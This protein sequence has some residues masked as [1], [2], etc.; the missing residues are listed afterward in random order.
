MK[1]IL[2]LVLATMFFVFSCG[3]SDKIT[4]KTVSEWDKSYSENEGGYEEEDDD[5][6]FCE[7]TGEEVVYCIRGDY[8]DEVVDV[9]SIKVGEKEFKC[10]SGN[11]RDC[12]VKMAIYCGEFDGEYED[13]LYC[14]EGGECSS[15]GDSVK[16]CMSTTGDEK[17]YYQVGEKKFECTV[18]TLEDCL[19]AFS[20]Y[21]DGVIEDEDE[22]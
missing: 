4:C 1:K 3:G 5:S 16:Y 17:V 20:K 10:G 21:C 13:G 8:N 6:I 18:D 9:Y 22:E 11:A 19:Y 12:Y 15:T 7:T 14:E 2:I